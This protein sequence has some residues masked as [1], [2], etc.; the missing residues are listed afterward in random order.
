MRC[1]RFFIG[2]TVALLFGMLLLLIAPPASAAANTWSS[3]APLATARYFHTATLLPSGKVL[4]AGGKD[5]AE[6]PHQRRTLRSGH[7]Y[8]EC[9]GFARV[10][11]LRA[12]RD[13]AALG[14]GA[15]GGGGNN[16]AELYDPATNSWS[17]ISVLATARYRQTATLLPSGKVLVAGGLNGAPL[18]SAELYDPAT[19]SWSAAGL[20]GTGRYY[21]TATLLPSGKVLATAGLGGNGSTSSPLTSAELYDPATNT[22]SA[23]ASLSTARYWHTA[24]LLPSGKVLVVGDPTALSSVVPSCTIRLTTPGAERR[25][26]RARA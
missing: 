12:H 4:V 6:T 22:W 5:G 8:L 3:A 20:L 10:P 1:D 25:R 9:G 24:T 13:A 2:R 26:S 21:H 23:A 11:A 17:S 15:G 7:Q 16:V 19:N 14:Q 18:T